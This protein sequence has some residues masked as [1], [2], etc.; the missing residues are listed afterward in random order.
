MKRYYALGL[1]IL[2][3]CTQAQAEYNTAYVNEQLT[4]PWQLSNIRS[5]HSFDIQS[6]L[7]EAENHTPCND[8][9]AVNEEYDSDDLGLLIEDRMRFSHSGEVYYTNDTDSYAQWTFSDDEQ[10]LILSVSDG[11]VRFNNYYELIE[12]TPRSLILRESLDTGFEEYS[13]VAQ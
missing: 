9:A 1:S 4:Q 5:Q 12:L 8:D 3:C 10:Y 11:S 2:F 13:F 7:A 6:D